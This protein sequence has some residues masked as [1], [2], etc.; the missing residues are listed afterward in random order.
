MKA[1]RYGKYEGKK[2]TKPII[3]TP[4]Q[5]KIINTFY[6]NNRWRYRVNDTIMVR[7]KNL[8][9]YIPMARWSGK[10][11]VDVE[12][13]VKLNWIRHL[14]GPY[15]EC[16]FDYDDVHPYDVGSGF[17]VL[18]K[19]ESKGFT[20]FMA[21]VFGSLMEKEN[22]LNLLKEVSNV[23]EGDVAE[24]QIDEEKSV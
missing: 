1:L 13:Q 17:Y 24:T 20:P 15:W 14:V 2:H 9:L 16:G 23:Q 7:D 21:G 6:M 4:E 12:I 8:Y 18:K 19:D 11:D 22:F 3:Y 10:K 5:I